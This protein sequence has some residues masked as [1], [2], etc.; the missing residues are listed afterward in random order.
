MSADRIP[1]VVLVKKVYAEKSLRNRKRKWK[2]RHIDGLHAEKGSVTSSGNEDYTDFLA[3]LEE[4]ADLR[5]NINIYKDKKRINV[6]VDQEEDNQEIPQITLSEMLDD[7]V[8]D[9]MES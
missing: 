5:A 1:D 2:L 6:Q 9:S 8:I 3:D 7:L 4:D